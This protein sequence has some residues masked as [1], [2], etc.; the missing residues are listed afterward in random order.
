ME[1]SQPNNSTFRTTGNLQPE[2]A[3]RKNKIPVEE[4]VKQG[5]CWLGEP[6]LN[7][8]EHRC[9]HECSVIV[10]VHSCPAERVLFYTLQCESL[11][12]RMDEK[13]NS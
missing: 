9:C 8:A 13:C 11:S 4:S 10:H 12:Y 7:A 6:N 3:A 5:Q 1:K 2:C